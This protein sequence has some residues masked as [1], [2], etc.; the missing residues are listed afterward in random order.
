MAQ[1]VA[2]IQ[3]RMSST[4]LPG[5]VLK[6][7]LG[8]PMI[9]RLL[10]RVQRCRTIDRLAVITS[11][12]ESDAPLAAYVQSLG[13]DCYRGSLQDVLDRYYQAAKKYE[14]THVVRITGDCP[15]LDPVLTD[16]VVRLL[17]E[18]P[19]DITASGACDTYPDGLDVTALTM[20]ALTEGWEKAE[21]PSEREHVTSYHFTR[22]QRYRCGV[23]HCPEKLGHIR[24]SVDEPEDFQLAE[25][26]FQALYP[27]NPQFSFADVW[28]LLQQHPQWLQGNAH[29]PINEGYQKS[30]REDEQYLRRKQER[31]E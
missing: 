18:G 19:Y 5:K 4:R 25:R 12:E 3:A 27:E 2:L 10:E 29:I 15:L 13:V 6:P 31:Q 26:I 7:L 11:T 21:L 20:K 23:V 9:G 22:P 14:A 8:Q 16:E 24:L 28:A 30:L 1:V 17:L